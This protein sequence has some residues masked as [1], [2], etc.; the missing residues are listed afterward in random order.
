MYYRYRSPRN[1]GDVLCR[2]SAKTYKM[3]YRYRS[4]RNTGDVLCRYSAKTYKM[5]T[6][7]IE[8]I[9]IQVILAVPRQLFENRAFQ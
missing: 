2:Y 1:T 5:N 4:P 3:Y 9:I 6:T 7:D 8:V